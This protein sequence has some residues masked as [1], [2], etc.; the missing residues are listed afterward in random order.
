MEIRFANG[1]IMQSIDP[2]IEQEDCQIIYC[3]KGKENTCPKKEYCKRYLRADEHV[4]LKLY[5]TSCTKD[6][7]FL[8]FLKENVDSG[9]ENAS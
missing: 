3:D 5:K 1:S 6:N 4:S 2:P 9:K 7:N 8:L